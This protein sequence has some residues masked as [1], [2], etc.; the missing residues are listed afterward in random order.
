[1]AL[2]L[3]LTSF[4]GQERVAWPQQEPR[5]RACS[6]PHLRVEEHTQKG[7]A[8]LCAAVRPELRAPFKSTHPGTPGWLSWL[9][10]CLKLR[11]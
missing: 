6:P 4:P 5:V 9:R 3:T 8:P 7:W 2:F 1:M 10:P 11:S